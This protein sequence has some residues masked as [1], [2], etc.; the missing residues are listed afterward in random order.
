MYYYYI[1]LDRVPDR[2]AFI[3]D[4]FRQIGLS[5]QLHRVSATDA[6]TM[7]P[8]PSYCPHRWGPRWE[9]S[10]SEVACFTSHRRTWEM[11]IKADLEHAVILEDDVLLSQ[12]MEAA[13][14]DI[15]LRGPK[16]FDVI[17]LDGV[18]QI[19]RYGEALP[20]GEARHVSEI[21]QGMAS[22]G[23]YLVSRR[24]AEWLLVNSISFCDH[25][26]DFVF[27]PASGR[28][29]MQLQSAVALQAMWS[30]QTGIE[31]MDYT[32]ATSERTQDPLINRQIAKGPILYRLKKDLKRTGRK[33]ART[34][35]QD[36]SLI[37]SGG[38]IGAPQLA[39]DLGRY[40]SF[41]IAG[42]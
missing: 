25:L 7:S 28:K 8:Q 9:L 15:V 5:S 12:E 27:D 41:R 20:I 22:A 24:G 29:I 30:E 13:V 34:L 37:A 33:L 17:K 18:P 32:V 23:C 16:D 35:Y 26:D 42:T 6:L 39:Q 14:Q 10:Q 2:A 36:R 21:L 38:V 19:G 31:A 11:V 40:R 4:Q 1:N 3:E